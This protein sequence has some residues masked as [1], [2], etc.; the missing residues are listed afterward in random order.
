MNWS[1]PAIITTAVCLAVCIVAVMMTLGA[2]VFS[3]G[4]RN[5]GLFAACAIGLFLGQYVYKSY[6]AR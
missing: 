4:V 3:S 1:V 2:I 5:A 6:V